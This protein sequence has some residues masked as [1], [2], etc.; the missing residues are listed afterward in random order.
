VLSAWEAFE[1]GTMERCAA[2]AARPL[3]GKPVAAA[4]S[5]LFGIAFIPMCANSTMC[6]L[7]MWK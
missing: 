5:M 2:D 6:N 1:L 7:H 3:E 4:G